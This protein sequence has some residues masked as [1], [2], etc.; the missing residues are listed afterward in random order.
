MHHHFYF[1]M[2]VHFYL[3]LPLTSIGFS[4]VF[5]N[6]NI[7]FVICE[8]NMGTKTPKRKGY[9][10]D[11]DFQRLGSYDGCLCKRTLSNNIVNSVHS[12]VPKFN[13]ASSILFAFYQV[14]CRTFML[15]TNKHPFLKVA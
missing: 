5:M 8:K 2:F 15:S 14:Y 9:E 12:V 3:I 10:L 13:T 1:Y 7:N 11:G 4:S 6:K